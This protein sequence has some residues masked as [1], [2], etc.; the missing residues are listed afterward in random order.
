MGRKQLR[1]LVRVAE[2]VAQEIQGAGKLLLR[3]A[4]QDAQHRRI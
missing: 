2:N 4:P 1:L 3:A